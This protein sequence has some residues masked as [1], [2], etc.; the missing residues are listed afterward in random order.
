[1]SAEKRM[2]AAWLAVLLL[3]GSY[4]GHAQAQQC[5]S[6]TYKAFSALS[7][8]AGDSATLINGSNTYVGASRLRVSNTA[9]GGA[10]FSNDSIDDNHYASEPGIR[11][12]QRN[13]SASA[14]LVTA[15]DFREPGNLSV[16]RP[17]ANLTIRLHDIDAGDSVI[18]NA[19][20]QNGTLINLTSANYSFDNSD[21]TSYVSY[22]GS[23]R[24]TS[25]NTV[26]SPSNQRRGTVNLSFSGLQVRRIEFRYYDA[27]TGGSYTIAELYGCSVPLTLYKVTRPVSGGS[28][29]FTLVNTTRITASVTTSSAGTPT[30]VDGNAASGMQPFTVATPGS[31]VTINE[32]TIP[33]GWSLADATCSNDAGTVIGSRNGN[34]YILPAASTAAGEALTCT[35]T[36]SRTAL[37]LQKALP[38]GRAAA[39]DQF[40][41]SI[42]GTGAPAAVT[43]TGTGSTATGAVAHTTATA[44]SAYTLSESGA[45]G[46]SLTRYTT[47]YSCTNTRPG[48]QT[49][50]GSGT[51]FTVTPVAGDDLTCTFSNARKPQLTLIKTVTNDNG[52]TQPATAWTLS[53][54]GP[55]SISG[56]TGSA[57]VTQASVSPGTYTLSESTL[58]A[59]YSATPYSCAI[60]GGVPASG[61]GIT[62]AMGDTAVCTIHNDDSNET[63]ISIAKAA[64]RDDV[65][66]GGLVSFSLVARNL[67]P[68]AADGA[69]LRDPAV[70][71]L[72]CLEAGL[73]A[74][75]CAASG[76]AACPASLT[77]AGLQSGVAVPTLPSGGEVIVGLTCRVTAT[78]VP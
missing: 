10:T 39:T 45:A 62:L 46:A 36:N 34:S 37:R 1:M 27:T 2:M 70:A 18:V 42:A 77:A 50:S 31:A 7:G 78:G 58:P 72:D 65:V 16:Y 53:A 33:S 51:S 75:T 30:Q 67:G 21:G 28:F 66:S 15:F 41:L 48:G 74:P 73:P 12:G 56:A 22:A 17:V 55:T 38:H 32:S 29:G 68:A 19:Y 43:T 59:G 60:N 49:P 23:N 40:T 14:Q 9:T 71:G 35:F 3:S 54:T 69:V 63:D 64:T 47:T 13:T 44:G 20:N 24:F 57:A 52:G 6:G 11:I 76:S 61:N 8:Q 4:A 25:P 26:D 5:S